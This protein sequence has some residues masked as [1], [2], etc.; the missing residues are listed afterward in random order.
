MKKNV[1][2]L[3]LLVIIVTILAGTAYADIAS[4]NTFDKNNTESIDHSTWNTFLE[5]YIVDN[6]PSG[7][8]RVR[9]GAVSDDDRRVLAHYI[10]SL[11]KT[12]IASFNRAEQKAYWINLYNAVTIDLILQHYPVESIRKIKFNFFTIGP[13]RELLVIVEGSRLSLDNI[14]H[15][16]LREFWDDNRIHYALNCASIGCPNIFKKAFT[17]QNTDALLDS[18]ASDY[19][20][21]SRGVMTKKGILYLSSI[22]K[23]FREDFDDSFNGVLAHLLTYSSS[24]L[25]INLLNTHKKV[26]YRYDWTLND[27]I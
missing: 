12:P 21:H 1:Y 23:W 2:Y 15:D 5:K 26:K 8:N 24:E 19:I 14:E 4:L 10:K 7:I 11:E 9:Y 6:H 18:G 17:A 25:E 13:W 27:A 3:W 22:Y 16:I 20:N